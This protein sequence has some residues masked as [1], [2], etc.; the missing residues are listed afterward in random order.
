MFV[1]SWKAKLEYLI[2]SWLS[3][4]KSDRKILDENIKKISSEVGNLY[5]NDIEFFN[6]ACLPMF[7]HRAFSTTAWA[8]LRIGK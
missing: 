4:K 6:P 3:A 5:P 1:N 2:L 7:I 8:R